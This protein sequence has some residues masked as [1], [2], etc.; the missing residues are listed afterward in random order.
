MMKEL[1]NNN[2]NKD[3]QLIK[4]GLCV[5]TN[6]GEDH[7]GDI[8]LGIQIHRIFLQFPLDHSFFHSIEKIWID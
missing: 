1:N 6:A 3:H 2:S 7:A 5:G 8:F 4:I